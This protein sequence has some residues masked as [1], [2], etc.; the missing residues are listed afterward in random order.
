LSGIIPFT[1][2][3]KAEECILSYKRGY[4][5]ITRNSS[6]LCTIATH[7]NSR[8]SNGHGFSQ[9]ILGVQFFQS[10]CALLEF[11]HIHPSPLTVPFLRCAFEQ[12]KAWPL[13]GKGCRLACFQTNHEHD[14]LQPRSIPSLGVAF[15]TLR[16]L[17]L[18][19]CKQAHHSEVFHPMQLCAL[20]PTQI[21]DC[22]RPWLHK[23]VTTQVLNV[24]NMRVHLMRHISQPMRA[25]AMPWWKGQAAIYGGEGRP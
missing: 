14:G 21:H 18:F 19:G 8:H 6:L 4:V 9:L 13:M 22:A 5:T 23:S 10:W 12:L 3:C 17:D 7:A 24:S 1:P 20:E 15:S 25:V 2:L 11:V 16:G